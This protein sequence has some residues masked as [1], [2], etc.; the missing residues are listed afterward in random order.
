MPSEGQSIRFE[1]TIEEGGH[2]SARELELDMSGYS[3]LLGGG[4]EKVVEVAVIA[5]AVGE[6]TTVVEL[7]AE[8]GA[9]SAVGGAREG[10]TAELDDDDDD[11]DKD[12]G[13]S[14]DEEAGVDEESGLVVDGAE[15]PPQ[16]LLM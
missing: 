5:K 7:E 9:S 16:L 1:S 2:D 10:T 3:E 13:G 11:D 14:D 6:V 4:S 8:Q 15:P 12:N